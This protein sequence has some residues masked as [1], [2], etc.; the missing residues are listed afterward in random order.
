MGPTSLWLGETGRSH[1]AAQSAGTMLSTIRLCCSGRAGLK[2]Y[3]LLHTP[4]MVFD[5]HSLLLVP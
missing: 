2:L 5:E 3:C 4:T 1:S